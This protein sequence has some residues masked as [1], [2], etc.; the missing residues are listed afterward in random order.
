LLRG[1]LFRLH[2]RRAADTILTLATATVAAIAT[3]APPLGLLLAIAMAAGLYRRA[4]KA[5]WRL[6]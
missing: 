3:A 2:G 1:W 5:S 6:D 4:A